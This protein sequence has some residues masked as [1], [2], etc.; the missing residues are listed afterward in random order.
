MPET[1]A[2]RHDPA[3]SVLVRGGNA[4]VRWD[5]E[6]A[7]LAYRHVTF[8]SPSLGRTVSVPIHGS[9]AV[10]PGIGAVVAGDDGYVR[11]HA[12]GLE[13]VYWERRLSAGVYASVVVDQRGGGIVV[14]TTNGTVAYLDL[15]GAVKWTGTA[16]GPVYGTP[17]VMPDADLLVLSTFHSHCV[18]L[19]LST[20]E[21]VFHRDLPRP[22]QAEHA[23]PAAHRDPY[24]SPV[25]TKD[26]V[27]VACAEH[28]LCLEPDG[29]ERW[30]REVG[31]AVKASPAVIAVTGE[32]VVPSVDGRCLFL[33]AATGGT[34][35]EIFAGGKL[36]ASPA[37]SGEVLA[38]GTECGRVVAV[39]TSTK[40]VR[41]TAAHGAPKSYTSFSVTPSGDFI[42][43]S[44]NGNVVCLRRD[45]GRFLWESSQ[46]LGLPDHDPVMDVT[47]IVAPDG[48]MYCASYSG[49][50]YEF[51]FPPC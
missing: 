1:A 47:P 11:F 15:R 7:V 34:N 14:A 33:D 21:Q 20:G 44:S 48:W 38:L 27:V 13:K 29:T 24:A 22:W 36:I 50:L 5:R 17:V 18:G 49:M 16:P 2:F 28:L 45:D 46:V 19:R 12:R 31:A 3:R 9:P 4:A 26:A 30:V 43:T 35:A 10:V 51:R 23:A 41:W 8:D 25:A 6:P 40:A 32:V 37:V 42:A 39:D